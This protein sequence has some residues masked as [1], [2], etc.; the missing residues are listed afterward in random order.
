MKM[1]MALA[2]AGALMLAGCGG[3]SK[4]GAGAGMPSVQTPPPTIRVAA[5][6]LSGEP[7]TPAVAVEIPDNTVEIDPG[8]TREM[9]V[10]G[11]SVLVR[12][13]SGGAS[14]HV[15]VHEGGLW[16]RLDGA[17]PF[18]LASLPLPT[19]TPP[20]TP[21]TRVIE[22]PLVSWGELPALVD[23]MT[24]RTELRGRFFAGASCE[25]GVTTCFFTGASCEDGVT[26]CQAVVKDLL[27]VAREQG[28]RSHRPLPVKWFGASNVLGGRFDGGWLDNSIFIV[29]TPIE[30][31]HLLRDTDYW[32]NGSFG[33][34]FI[35]MGIRDTNPVTGVYRG[36]ALFNLNVR[37]DVVPFE[38]RYTSNDA[39]GQLDMA[40]LGR[41]EG[42]GTWTNISVDNEGYFKHDATFTDGR[43]G[44][45]E[46]EGRFYQG[47]EVGG[48][49]SFSLAAG[50][51]RPET[52][53][54]GYG[55]FGGKLV[56]A[57]P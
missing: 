22:P 50:D 41:Y 8:Q 3:G 21:P 25:D 46:L 43:E 39:G 33:A 57:S 35:S 1:L 56:P 6:P 48:V 29:N 27:A 4:G 40:L 24:H 45:K 13:P 2:V 32:L 11:R 15:G 44:P 31:T 18:A 16:Y 10:G 12:C 9:N 28:E 5:V 7:E 55:A 23:R 52:I 17:V 47:G 38:L 53:M 36:G 20:T 19:P 42:L 30:R 54:A 37:A 51:G 34:H 49:Y 14:C 26:A